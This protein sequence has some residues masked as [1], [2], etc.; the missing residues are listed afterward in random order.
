MSGV[1]SI[2]I[3]DMAPCSGCTVQEGLNKMAVYKD[4]KGALHKYSGGYN[5]VS[6]NKY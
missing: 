6:R 5:P 2:D 4:D 1:D 3:E